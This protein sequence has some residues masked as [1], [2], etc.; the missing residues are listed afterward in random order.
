MAAAHILGYSFEMTDAQ[1]NVLKAHRTR[2]QKRGLRRVEVTVRSEDIELV[3]DVAAALRE[4]GERARWMRNALRDAAKQ[5]AIA[6]DLSSLPDISAPELDATFEDVDHSRHQP[7][8]T[9]VRDDL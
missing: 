8:T 9:K 2:L 1:K 6:E 7:V 3:R 4:D 5:P